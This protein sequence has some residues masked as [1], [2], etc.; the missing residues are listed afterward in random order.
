MSDGRPVSLGQG[1][2]YRLEAAAWD[3]VEFSLRLLPVDWASAFG[4]ALLRTLGPMSPVQRTVLRNL[5]LAFPEMSRE[6]RERLALA[7]WENFGR[8]C[9]EF[10]M[11]D[12]LTPASGR[13]EIVGAEHLAEIAAGN[14]AVFVS[15][16]FANWEVMP[17]AGLAAG[18][19]C[20]ITYRRANNPY[21]DKRFLKSRRKYGVRY[22]APKQVLEANREMLAALGR[23]ESVALL[24]DQKFNEGLP[25]SFFGHTAMTA[26][27]P[28]RMALRTC[29]RLHLAH[30]ERLKGARYRVVFHPPLVLQKTGN[31]AAD[32]QWGVEK[33]T[34]FIEARVRERPH[35]WFWVHK[36]W[37]DAAYAAL[38]PE[39][40]DG[41]GKPG[42]V[43]ALASS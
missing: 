43:A 30:I 19:D 13:I 16:H 25:V 11:M 7:Q 36:R 35:E 37:T 12:R 1:L 38:P 17:A 10:M 14:P 42:Q 26:S 21:I 15:G 28:T 33:V 39:S 2:I 8:V 40:A 6:E 5:R 31:R 34:E 27:G 20:Q 24:N 4:G 41:Q 9:A 23:G 29:G 22:F 18:I 32:I 3:V